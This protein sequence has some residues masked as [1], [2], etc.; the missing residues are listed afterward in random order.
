MFVINISHAAVARPSR[1]P[2]DSGNRRCPTWLAAPASANAIGL[3]HR[4]PETM[5]R[6]R[7][8]NPGE[9]TA[10]AGECLRAK[11]ER[12]GLTS[13]LRSDHASK[14]GEFWWSQGES[15]P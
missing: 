10:R 4:E 15:N 14:P 2:R 11:S 7:T 5:R 3:H 6:L 13:A 8:P 9:A 12:Y 1:C